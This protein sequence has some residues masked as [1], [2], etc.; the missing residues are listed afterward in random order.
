MIIPYATDAPIYHFPAATL[1]LIVTNTAI[2]IVSLSVVPP[3]LFEP[4]VMKLGAGLHPLQWLSHN[5][6]HADYWHLIGNMIFLWSYGLIVEGKI[7]WWRFL[8]AYLLIGTVHGAAIQSMYAGQEEVQ[9]VLG[10]SGAI[11]GLMAICMIWAPVND[12]SCFFLFIVGF[13]II[14]NTVNLPIY[15]FAI[16]QLV[17]QGLGMMFAFLVNGD[18]MSSELL[19]V[20]GA[21]WGLMVGIILLKTHQ[22]DCEGWDVFSLRDR[23]RKLRADWKARE[24]RL[25]LSKSNERLSG[26]TIRPEDR[27]NLDPEKRAALLLKRMN[28]SIDGGDPG[29]LTAT[30][31]KWAAAYQNRPPR[32]ELF[33]LIRRLHEAKAWEPSVPLMR[34]YCRLYPDPTGRVPLKLGTILIR[35]RERPQEGL[36]VLSEIQPDALEPAHEQ[37]RQALMRQAREM[38]EEGVLELEE[39]LG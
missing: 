28:E 37:A 30:Y 14:T 17:L 24:A 1:G 18:P 19:H 21:G 31:T 27:P 10:A 29:G 4:W 12:L 22:V 15:A 35:Y 2:A 5:F 34:T 8:L 7:G 36:Q 20:S 38:I 33:G 11:F 26:P 25:E 16:V 13:R 39:D 3:E 32:K 6:M 9:Y 23:K